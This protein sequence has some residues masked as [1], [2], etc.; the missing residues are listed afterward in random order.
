MFQQGVILV[1]GN[2]KFE[3]QFCLNSLAEKS[4]SILGVHRG[5]RKQ[6]QELVD[7]FAEGKVRYVHV[8]ISGASHWR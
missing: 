4:Q 3:V 2:S 7:T 5:T 8:H 1:G 6:L